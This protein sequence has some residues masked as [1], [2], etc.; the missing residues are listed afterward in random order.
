MPMAGLDLKDIDAWFREHFPR[1]DKV[2]RLEMAEPRRARI[3]LVVEKH[4]LR[5]GGTVSG[6]S[7]ML[8]AD[9][10]VYAALLA[11]DAEAGDAVTSNFNIS[12]LRRP[13]PADLLAEAELLSVGRRLVVGEVHLRS[14][15]DDSLLAQATVTYSRP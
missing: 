3:R 2:M 10:A 9:A 6:P 12:F 14:D 5:P 7:M 15:G 4:H 11:E 13:R 8:L 1:F